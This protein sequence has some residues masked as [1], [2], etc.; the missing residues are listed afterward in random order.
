VTLTSDIVILKVHRMDTLG[1][2]NCN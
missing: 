2:H 1:K